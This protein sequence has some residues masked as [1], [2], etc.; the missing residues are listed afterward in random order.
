M[1]NNKGPNNPMY[2]KKHTLESKLKIGLIHKGKVLSEES[3]LKISISA[4]E[5]IRK[6]TS[7]ETKLKIGN[8]NRG[9]IKGRVPWNKG[10]VGIQRH[11][12]ES[13]EKMSLS[14]KGRVAWN[15]GLKG[16]YV[17]RDETREK[18]RKVMLNGGAIKAIKGIK[19]PSKQE[20]ILRDYIKEIYPK[21]EFQYQ[22]LNY[23]LDI[24]ILEYKIAIEYDG[25]YHFDCQEHIDYHNRRQREIENMGWKFIRY[26]IFKPFPSKDVILLDLS[27]VGIDKDAT[28]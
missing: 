9:K 21:C 12:V 7:D 11:S 3:K 16:V 10:K 25:W 18:L 5:R 8:S 26:N 19:N 20:V 1:R 15:K 28:H 27:K 24:A 17:V 4:K 13:R 22:V 6:P 2:G 14:R 23:S